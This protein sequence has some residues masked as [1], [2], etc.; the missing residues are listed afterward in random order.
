MFQLR[1]VSD[2]PDCVKQTPLH[3]SVTNTQ[4]GVMEALIAAGA[5]V[6]TRLVEIILPK[7]KNENLCAGG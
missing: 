7:A 3:Y 5:E 4:E 1:N 2:E 6:N